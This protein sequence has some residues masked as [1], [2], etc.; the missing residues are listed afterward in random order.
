MLVTGCQTGMNAGG[1]RFWNPDRGVAAL[2]QFFRAV[3]DQ[4][5]RLLQEEGADEVGRETPELTQ[6]IGPEV[7]FACSQCASL[8]GKSH[9]LPKMGI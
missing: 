1:H 8:R 2:V 9:V 5:S 6:L 4:D 3:D 7:S